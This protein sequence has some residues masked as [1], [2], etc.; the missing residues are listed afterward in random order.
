MNG[1]LEFMRLFHFRD[2]K[3]D[4]LRT[5]YDEHSTLYNVNIFT[6]IEFNWAG[7][8]KKNRKLH[9]WKSCGRKKNGSN[10]LSFHGIIKSWWHGRYCGHYQ[11]IKKRNVRLTVAR[12]MTKQDFIKINEPEIRN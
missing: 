1:F 10:G 12:R 11:Q 2:D 6:Y 3:T 8:E 7:D 5:M 4:V 9:N